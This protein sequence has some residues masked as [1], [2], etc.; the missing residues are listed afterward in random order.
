MSNT[1]TSNDT[2][3]VPCM[4][5]LVNLYSHRRRI[6]IQPALDC[7][8]GPRP[9]SHCAKFGRSGCSPI[10][11]R[12]MPHANEVMDAYTRLQ[13]TPESDANRD[14]M[15]KTFIRAHNRFIYRR[16]TFMRRESS[17][18]APAAPTSRESREMQRLRR[19]E[20][21][22]NWGV[23]LA[24]TNANQQQAANANTNTSRP[25]TEANSSRSDT[26]V[27]SSRSSTNVDSSRPGTEVNSSRSDTD[28]N[29]SESS[30]SGTEVKSNRPGTE[31]IMEQRDQESN[32]A[33]SNSSN[34]RDTNQ[35]YQLYPRDI[36]TT[37]RGS[38]F[39]GVQPYMEVLGSVSNLI[40][41]LVTQHREVMESNEL[42]LDTILQK[43]HGW[44]PAGGSTQPHCPH[45]AVVVPSRPAARST[46]A[47]SGSHSR[48]LRSTTSARK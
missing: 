1:P 44:G 36:A 34:T 17:V 27:D 5:C 28:V 14:T 41:S 7:Q 30:R 35:L 42:L 38:F 37:M 4:R 3:P 26:N 31:V 10:C 12:L 47:A 40:N 20:V 25:G 8:Q 16:Q 29:S 32:N 23:H 2:M 46:T 24:D 43:E 15:E 6:R 19:R 13:R 11:N 9:C 48:V 39:S 18:A 33:G 21:D 22:P 45:I